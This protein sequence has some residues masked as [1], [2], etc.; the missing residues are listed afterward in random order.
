MPGQINIETWDE[1]EIRLVG[2]VLRIDLSCTGN[3]DDDYFIVQTG[4]NGIQIGVRRKDII[5]MNKKI[6]INSPEYEI[7]E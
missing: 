5:K 1:V 7:T 6:C 4:S 2:R 3:P